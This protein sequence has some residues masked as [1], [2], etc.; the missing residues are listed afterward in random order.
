MIFTSAYSAFGAFEGSTEVD[1]VSG[2]VVVAGNRLRDRWKARGGRRRRLGK[3][4][5]LER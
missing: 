2:E 5:W 3:V 1:I 4:F